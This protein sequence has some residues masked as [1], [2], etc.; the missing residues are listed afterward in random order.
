MLRWCE[1]AMVATLTKES[2]QLGLAYF[3]SLLNGYGGKHGGGAQ[4]STLLER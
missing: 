2:D 3:Q 1:D 4:E